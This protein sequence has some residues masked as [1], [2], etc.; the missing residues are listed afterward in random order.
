MKAAVVIP[1]YNESAR[2][3]GLLKE[4][5]GYLASDGR[6]DVRFLVVDDGSREEEGRRMAGLVADLGLP[7]RVSLMRLDRNRGKGGALKAGFEAVL[8]D[9]CECAG[10]MDADG[11][12]PVSQLDKLLR[13]LGA[14]P[15]LA[16]VLGSRVKL[17]GSDV[18]RNELRHYLGR[19]FATIVSLW[20]GAAVYDLQ[21]GLK[22][23]RA[24]VL[25][26]YLDRPTDLR[27]VWDSQLVL[28]MVR[29]GEAL[30]E[31]PIDWRE[32]PGSKV[33]LLRDPLVMLVRLLRFK[34]TLK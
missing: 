30:A 28:A 3:G 18:R 15:G 1:A 14:D 31:V 24:P 26:R 23:F 6:P 2:L 25:K 5:A 32:V 22:V 19:I 13:R 10:F 9:G 4:I 17:L 16:G 29:G 8:K 11:A 7:E 27:W 12:S 34:R 33:S 21:C 20:F